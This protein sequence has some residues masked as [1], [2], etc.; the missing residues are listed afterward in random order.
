MNNEEFLNEVQE[1]IQE[2]HREFHLAT[3]AHE[4]IHKPEK[5]KEFESFIS[6]K[7]DLIREYAR[8]AAN[9]EP[10]ACCKVMGKPYCFGPEAADW[11]DHWDVDELKSLLGMALGLLG[12]LLPEDE[13]KPEPEPHQC[14]CVS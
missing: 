4:I 14:P 12:Q 7:A 9:H 3:L 11:V 10:A 2:L 1:A 13:A 6:K 5:K 8:K